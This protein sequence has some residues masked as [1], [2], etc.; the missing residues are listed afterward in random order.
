VVS[1][2][3]APARV[4]SLECRSQR[5]SIAA[6]VRQFSHEGTEVLGMLAHEMRNLLNNA[7]MSFASIRKGVVS[8]GGSTGAIHERSLLRLHA[9]IDR[10]LADVRLDAG[11]QNIEIVPVWEIFEEVEI[12][13]LMTARTRGVRFVVTSVDPAVVVKADR[14]TLAAAVANLLQNAFKFTRPGTAVRLRAK[15]DGDRVVRR[16]HEKQFIGDRQCR[17]GPLQRQVRLRRRPLRTAHC[18]GLRAVV[19][20]LR[21]AAKCASSTL[22][23]A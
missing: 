4:S 11:I 19:Q 6:R 9:L 2:H 13:A 15:I 3:H 1:K 21:D 7:L 5:R 14:Q 17:R 20:V 16:L 8:P 10:S 23:L 22:G 18:P 12:G